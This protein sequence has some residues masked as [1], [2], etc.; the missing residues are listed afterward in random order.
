MRKILFL[1]AT[2]SC[3]IFAA[4]FGDPLNAYSDDNR[5]A[6]SSVSPNQG[7]IG[8]SVT[9]LGTGFGSSP[10]T[11]NF[12]SSHALI[13]SWQSSTIKVT[14]PKGSGQVTVVVIRGERKS[15]GVS[16]TYTPT[17]TPSPTPTPTPTPSPS[18]TPVS[19]TFKVLANNDLGMHCVDKEFSVFSIL[20]PYNVVNAQ[21]VQ[22]GTTPMVLDSTQ[23]DI[24]YSS[25]ADS[26]GS[27]NSTSKNKTDFWQNA[28]TL[29]GASLLPG[30]G[31][32]GLFMPAD[33]PG[34]LSQYSSF[35]WNTTKGTFD[36][37]GIPILPWDDAGNVNRY[38]L[39]R[40]SAYQKSTGQLLSST[41]I[42]LPV[43]EETTCTTCHATGRAAASNPALTWATDADLEIQ[44]RKNV[45][46]LH[47]SINGTNL[48]A[49]A[50][51]LCASCHYSPALDLAGAGPSAQQLLHPTMSK[52]MHGF[53]SNKMFDA[54]GTALA[55]SAVT[56]GGTPP[57]ADRQACYQ[58]HPGSTTKCFRGAMSST[59]SCQN[60]HGPM[61]AVGGAAVLKAGGSID[62]LN[63]G[64]FRRPW[65]DLPRC[66]S[67]H[68]GDAMSHLASPHILGP[69]GMRLFQAWDTGDASASPLVATNTRFAEE[70]GKLFR[71][72]KGHGGLACEACHGSTHAIW[73]AADGSNDNVA[74]TQLQGRPGTISECTACHGSGFALTTNGPHGMH[75]VNNPN[76]IQ[77]GHENFY[78]QNPSG[79]QACHGTDLRGT[80]LSRVPVDRTFSNG[81]TVKKGGMVTCYTCHN[82]PNGG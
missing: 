57:T 17:P 53:H 24:R 47:D 56:P 36:A 68:T 44:A 48:K 75:N 74:A 64:G 39:M 33:A 41:D 77:G 18:G 11:V 72:S 43:S 46:I 20:P 61:A 49:S 63:D 80:V 1:G 5:M 12:G 7:P 27:I 34:G 54:T 16:F 6:I 52:V 14:A 67:C 69:D 45:L 79:C 81:V 78:Q 10:G 73:P 70:S 19:G 31:L 21:V 15:N 82:G 38:P 42:V 22:T 58:C 2:L 76:W 62:G 29:Y 9:I 8:T 4:H 28:S 26:T 3:L 51:V 40:I 71:F 30:Q 55:D 25:V 66:G 35:Q 59:V 23:V 13:S 60:C 37:E 50:P 32:K 65:K